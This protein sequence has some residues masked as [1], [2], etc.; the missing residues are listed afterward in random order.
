M[1]QVS[2][3][4]AIMDTQILSLN[5][6]LKLSIAGTSKVTDSSVI[7]AILAAKITTLYNIRE[8]IVS[9]SSSFGP[10]KLIYPCTLSLKNSDCSLVN[11]LG[12]NVHDSH[13]G[14]AVLFLYDFVENDL[15]E[16]QFL[17]FSGFRSEVPHDFA[18]FGEFSEVFDALDLRGNVFL[19]SRT[20]S[21]NITRNIRAIDD[22]HMCNVEDA[23]QFSQVFFQVFFII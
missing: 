10:S 11:K 14:R 6:L 21:A 9:L 15:I 3:L 23:K 7:L 17:F 22:Q 4:E 5:L 13:V 20:V 2:L 8:A 1:F 16:G 12:S 18:L 19:N